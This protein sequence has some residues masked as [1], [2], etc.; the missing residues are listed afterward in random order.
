MKQDPI[1]TG[2][3]T[4]GLLVA[5][6]KNMA[7]TQAQSNLMVGNY[8]KEGYNKLAN[9]YALKLQQAQLDKENAFKQEGLNLQKQQITNQVQ[10]WWDTKK[11]WAEQNKL[12]KQKMQESARVAN[13]QFDLANRQLAYQK[14]RDKPSIE[15][16]QH[17]LDSLKEPNRHPLLQVPTTQDFGVAGRSAGIS[18]T[19]GGNG[20]SGAN[21]RNVEVNFGIIG[22]NIT[23]VNKAGFGPTKNTPNT[24]LINGGL[25]AKYMQLKMP[26][27]DSSSN[28]WFNPTGELYKTYMQS[29]M[30]QKDSKKE[31]YPAT[32]ML[33]DEFEKYFIP[34]SKAKPQQTNTQEFLI[35]A[36]QAVLI[37]LEHNMPLTP[38]DKYVANLMGIKW[39]QNEYRINEINKNTQDLKNNLSLLEI[40]AEL[41]LLGEEHSGIINN[42]VRWGFDTT[43]GMY[44][45]SSENNQILNLEKGLQ[46]WAVALLSRRGN[47]TKLAEKQAESYLGKNKSPRMQA[48]TLNALDQLAITDSLEIINNLRVKGAKKEALD[49][50]RRLQKYIN[51]NKYLTEVL[52]M[53][54]PIDYDT[55]GNIV[56]GENYRQKKFENQDIITYV[57]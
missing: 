54:S 20:G 35:P 4:L 24:A 53:E 49:Y 39:E 47:S 19:N 51:G 45:I 9:A 10:Q 12:E 5:N 44:P 1:N 27:K 42:M 6:T 36:Y 29:K 43:G 21:A 28:G 18:P 50:E 25:Y 31:A 2:S 23:G 32:K 48:E 11:Q 37:K 14:E 30:P 3:Y 7:D 40:T 41:K 38:Q 22:R 15:M 16:Q 26:Q 13:L 55:Y 34:A 17:Q 56:F 33:T 8:L 46:T 57:R 52:K